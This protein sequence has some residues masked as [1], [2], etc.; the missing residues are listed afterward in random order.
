ME[1]KRD[2]DYGNNDDETGI[3]RRV[4]RKSDDALAESK[5]MERSRCCIG[6]GKSLLS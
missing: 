4:D 5:T 6:W 3:E 2:R 1:L